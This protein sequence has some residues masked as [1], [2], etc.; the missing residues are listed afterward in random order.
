[1]HRTILLGGVY[2]ALVD[3]EDYERLSQWKWCAS[4]HGR[5]VYATRNA[6]SAEVREAGAEASWTIPMHRQIM[7]DP[8]GLYVHHKNGNGLDNRRHNLEAL[9]AKEHLARHPR[10]KSSWS[11]DDFMPLPSDAEFLEE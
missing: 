2:R 5:L 6:R 4:R 8:K 10:P 11:W 3:D 9:T 1:M 7:G